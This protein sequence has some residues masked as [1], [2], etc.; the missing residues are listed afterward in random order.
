MIEFL[1]NQ[2]QWF[3]IYCFEPATQLPAHTRFSRNF[4]LDF[5]GNL[6][7]IFEVWAT[8]KSPRTGFCGT[9]CGGRGPR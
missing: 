4:T 2:A 3:D 5:R 1:A 9:G 6:D 8:G 7:S